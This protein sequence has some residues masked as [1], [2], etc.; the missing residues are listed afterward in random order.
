M[1]SSLVKPLVGTLL[2]AA[3]CMTVAPAFSA[4]G[5]VDPAKRA[6]VST[7]QKAVLP[8]AVE[9][10]KNEVLQDRR[11]LTDSPREKREAIVGERRS[12]IAVEETREKK[13]APTR[14]L[15]EQKQ[16]PFKESPW[17]GKQSRFSTSE[18]AYR[19]RMAMRFQDKIGEASP[20]PQPNRT[21]TDQRTTFSKV[22]RFSFRRNSDQA[23]TVN[24]AGSEAAAGD[25]SN[26]SGLAP[27]APTGTPAG[28]R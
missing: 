5:R 23:I 16:I 9:M 19:S 15:I 27:G 7:E 10:K 14:E 4:P 6:R 24:A 20:F 17:N 1:P 25:V 3:M 18:D 8:D 21:V 13:M 2:A 11:F 12:S 28:G 22:N 26:R